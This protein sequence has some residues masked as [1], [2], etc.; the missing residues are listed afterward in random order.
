MSF[1][2]QT[3]KVSPS[4]FL[5]LKFVKLRDLTSVAYKRNL[6][7][8]ITRE[9]NEKKVFNTISIKNQNALMGKI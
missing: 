6:K 8:K 9:G 1:F 5:E 2:V 7:I 4:K 3:I